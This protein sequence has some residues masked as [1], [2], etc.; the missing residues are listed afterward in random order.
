MHGTFPDP[1][2]ADAPVLSVVMPVFNEE[3]ALPGVLAEAWS[4]LTASGVPF[5]YLLVD[6]A[7]TDRSPE[8]L[9][10]FRAQHPGHVRVLRN[11]TN[12]GTAAWPPARAGRCCCT[13]WPTSRPAGG[14][15][16]SPA[17]GPS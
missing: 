2:P 12:R 17:P 16:S 13:P 4:A 11:D 15:L 3:E 5:E 6:D 14:T 9:D 8:I 10:A 7:S 1:Q